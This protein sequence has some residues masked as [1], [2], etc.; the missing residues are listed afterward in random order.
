MP[1]PIDELAEEEA[2]PLAAEQPPPIVEPRSPAAAERPPVQ[3]RVEEPPAPAVIQPQ[4]ELGEEVMARAESRQHLPLTEATRPVSRPERTLPRIQA[5]SEE[6]IGEAGIDR[7]AELPPPSGAPSGD[8]P[9]PQPVREPLVERDADF[10]LAPLSRPPA[11]EAVQRLPL[12]VSPG[13]PLVQSAV[14]EGEAIVQR[15]EDEG[16]EPEVGDSAPDLDDLARQVF[17]FIKRMLAIERE[18]LPR[19]R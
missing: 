8:L 13:A 10:P 6:G 15:E 18:R 17:P 16:I 4:P 9:L 11:A 1:A 7:P 3:R 2:Q 14:G 12:T 19:F 5:R